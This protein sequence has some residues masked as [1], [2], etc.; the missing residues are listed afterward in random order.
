MKT[1][2]GKTI[3]FTFMSQP[4]VDP[5]GCWVAKLTFPGGSDLRSVFPIEI[6]QGDGKPVP[7]AV[8]EFAGRRLA[9]RDGHARISY[10]DF[11]KGK[12]ESGLF[13]H[14]KDV[15]EPIPGGLTFA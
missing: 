4:T 5:V 3:T 15:P 1:P 12:H 7:E 13:L 2:E 11:V 14:R 9:V 6:T 8:F 10:V